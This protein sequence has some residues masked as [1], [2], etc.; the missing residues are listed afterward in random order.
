MS[1]DGV[2]PQQRHCDGDITARSR[3]AIPTIAV[4]AVIAPISITL[5]AFHIGQR[6]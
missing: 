1:N 2:A 3:S 6:F 4:V 5:L